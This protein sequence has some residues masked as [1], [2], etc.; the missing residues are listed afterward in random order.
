MI[1]DNKV[2]WGQFLLLFLGIILGAVGGVIYCWGSV[3]GVDLVIVGAVALVF[4]AH[5]YVWR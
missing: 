3:L 4:V 2:R 5:W 1:R